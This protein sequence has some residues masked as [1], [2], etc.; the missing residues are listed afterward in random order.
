[1]AD[2]R[3]SRGSWRRLVLYLLFAL[4][5]A[6]AV[7]F[8]YSRRHELG[9]AL[10]RLRWGTVVL[11][12]VFGYLAVLAM[13][14]GWASAVRSG[15]VDLD[16][17]HLLR[18]YGVG[19]VGKYLP[20]S[21]WPVLAQARL[22]RRY[23]VSPGRV[24]AGSLVALAVSVLTGLIVGGAL[25]PVAGPQARYLL[26]A[27]VLAVPA[28]VLLYPP[29]LNW[30]LGRAARILR[31]GD[32]AFH[33]SWSGILRCGGWNVL[34]NLLF[35]LHLFVLADTLGASRPR[36][37]VLSLCAY[38]LA[39]SIGVAIIF[40]PAGSG[41]REAVLVAVLAPSLTADS[42][43]LIALV[44]RALLVIVDISLGVSQLH[45]LGK[46]RPDA[47]QAAP[48]DPLRPAARN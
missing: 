30:L 47:R 22:A 18:V 33:Y 32:V 5:V 27:P 16:R 45:G 2:H 20:G 3:L 7:W 4:C 46:L 37:Y 13:F 34:G 40:L 28:L 25:L 15:H 21:V 41:A 11:S 36:D 10:T 23:D 26:W 35:G 6:A 12:F 42:A 9:D 17:R 19:Q 38:A 1:M 8:L 43:L 29:L 44:S 14:L 24:A 31:R 39:S 48:D